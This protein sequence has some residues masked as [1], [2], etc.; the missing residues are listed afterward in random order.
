MIK[1]TID[2]DLKEKERKIRRQI[3]NSIF[4]FL[5]ITAICLLLWKLRSL[6]LPIVVGALLAYLFRPVKD[7]FQVSWLP[8]EL[9][10]LFLFACVGFGLFMGISRARK[11]IPDERQKL[12]LKVRLKF[13]VN[14]KF[15]EIVGKNEREK[16][17]NPVSQ[18]VSK[19]AGP[20]VDSLN[21]FL[22]LDQDEIDLFLKYRKGYKGEAPIEDKF[23]D[24][25]QA[26]LTTNKYAAEAKQREVASAIAGAGSGNVGHAASPE[27]ASENQPRDEIKKGSL[28]EDLSVWILAPLIFVFMGFDNGQIRK[29]VIGLVP[30]RYF[31]LSLTVLDMLD[32][33]IGNYLRGTLMEC[34]LVGITLTIGLFLL[35]IPVSL[36]LAIGFVSGLVNAIPFLGP[37]IGMVIALCYSLIAE[38]IQPI[39]PGL[40]SQDIA[41]Y[42]VA[43]VAITHVLDNV[44]FQPIVLGSAVNLHPLVVI[45]AIIG[46]SILMGV[47]G[48]LLAIP[49]VVIIKTAVE[50]LFKELKD[51]RII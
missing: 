21:H 33:A 49:T 24:Y 46:G 26:N 20:M 1:K 27:A 47:W 5:T 28:M 17:Q 32:E 29:Y 43:L 50:T 45:V 11:M 44:V 34:G 37:A 10:V 9:R 36:A 3:F 14:E 31:E 35:G 25:F 39:L 12:E 2:T 23:Y 38:N 48:M 18:L 4:S 16:R 40:A 51:Y 6:I 19:E 8:H 30:N 7:R 22:D 41:I 13:K 42:V 15:Q